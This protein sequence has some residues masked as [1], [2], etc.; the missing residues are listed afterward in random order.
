M[1]HTLH[2]PQA[3]DTAPAPAAPTAPAPVKQRDA[4]FDNAKFMTIVLVV[5]G[6]LWAQLQGSQVEHSA[7]MVIYAFHMPLFTFITGY[8][9]RGYVRSSDKLRSLVPTVIAPYVIFTLLSRANLY[10]VADKP[11]PADQWLEPHYVTWFLAAL[12]CWRLSAP[13]WRHLR[14]PITTSVV[15][16]LVVGGWELSSDKN[17]GHT[18]ILLPF[19]V[20]GLT[21]NTD[22]FDRLRRRARWWMGAPVLLGMFLVFYFGTSSSVDSRLMSFF[23]WCETYQQ[24]KLSLPMGVAARLAVFALAV[25]LGAAFLALVPKRRTWFTEL[26]T[27][28]MYVFLLHAL[29]LKVFDYTKL[30]DEPV[31]QSRAGLV[32]TTIAAVGL[33]VVLATEPVRRATRWLVEPPV[34]RLLSRRDAKS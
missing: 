11:F 9:S 27:R 16:A 12:V 23:Y 22:L 33:S 34:G 7:Y 17:V 20:L 18:I 30:I 5:V 21:V 14:Y 2:G 4:F 3:P 24:M 6:H 15:V 26:G 25:A 1:T 28:T 8:F 31:V 32:L 19:F 13:L 29:V 10:F